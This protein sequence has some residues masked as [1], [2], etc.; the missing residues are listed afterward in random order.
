[1]VITIKELLNNAEG[2][3]KLEVV[4]PSKEYLNSFLE[5]YK[6]YIELKPSSLWKVKGN[7]LC[8]D[9]FYYF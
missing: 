1:M 3:F 8:L 2:Q 9:R 4:F 7:R 6:Y 5:M